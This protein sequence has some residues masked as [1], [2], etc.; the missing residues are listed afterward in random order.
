MKMHTRLTTAAVLPLLA[1][2]AQ[3]SLSTHDRELLEHYRTMVPAPSASAPS[4]V[5][6]AATAETGVEHTAWNS[7][8]APT[9]AAV[10]PSVASP[11]PADP[12][13]LPERDLAPEVATLA[14]GMQADDGEMGKGDEDATGTDPRGFATKFMPYYRRTEL[15]NGLTEDQLTAFGLVRFDEK[16]AFTYEVPV[17]MSRDFSGISGFSG[18]Q[19]G[20]PNGAPA[21]GDVTG[22]GDSNIRM[23]SKFGEPWLGQDW[24][25]GVQLTFPT[26]SDDGLSSEKAQAGPMLVNVIDIPKL[27][28]FFAMMHIYQTDVFGTDDRDDIEIYVGRWFYMQPLRPPGE[29]ILDGIYLLTEFQPVYDF[30][31]SEFSFWVGPELGKI[32]GEGRILY[33]K[34][35]WGIDPEDPERKYTFEF[36]FRWFF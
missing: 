15:E 32:I 19:P 17:A 3:T 12:V 35:G 10:A 36:G 23:F 28:A 6:E 33:A 27:H 18:G 30:E 7:A 22:I 11:A 13:A 2:C 5:P 14:L 31:N 25:W 9:V 26:G 16:T 34:P 8:T 21:S 4:A 24:M 1:A 29:G 20:T